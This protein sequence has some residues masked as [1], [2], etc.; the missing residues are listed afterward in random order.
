[1]N[2]KPSNYHTLQLNAI[3]ERSKP[4]KKVIIK[5]QSIIIKSGIMN[6]LN[7][8]ISNCKIA[9]NTVFL[10]DPKEYTM[11][12]YQDVRKALL[13]AGA[14]YKRNSFIFP[15]DAQPYIDRITGGEKVNIKKEF[16]FFATPAKL[17]AKLVEMADINS[18]DLTVLEPSAGQGAI[19]K[20]ILKH[21]PGL[22]VHCYEL[23]DINR[24]VL[25]GIKD[26]VILGEDFL[27]SDNITK[28]AHTSTNS[29]DIKFDRII[30]NPPFNKN[31]DIEHIK[32]MY[33]R[34]NK[35]GR[36]VT[37]AS[38]HWQFATGKKETAFRNW[39]EEIGAI[40]EDIDAGEFKES[41][42]NIST[43]IILIDK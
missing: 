29:K 9:G 20:A 33:R 36:L 25:K 23:M 18:P 17:A 19:V 21:E 4:E 24:G 34:L 8:S 6:E 41:G 10:P 42:T 40:T 22:I 27:N 30:A 14:I 26:C 32:E 1:M 37:I 3:L 16:Q 12:N 5:K 13:N 43:C 11:S 7:E 39:I 35:N 15:S 28:G 38:K 2:D 31:Q